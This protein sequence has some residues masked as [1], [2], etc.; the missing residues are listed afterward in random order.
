MAKIIFHLF[1]YFHKWLFPVFLYS[2]LL[3]VFVR[4]CIQ[5]PTKYLNLNFPRFSKS[6]YDVNKPSFLGQILACSSYIFVCISNT[7]YRSGFSTKKLLIGLVLR[8]IR[9]KFDPGLNESWH[10]FRKLPP[11]KIKILSCPLL[12]LIFS[13]NTVILHLLCSL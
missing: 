9:E 4:N 12:K 11:S 2:F 7:L 3:I 5:W 10:D 13:E 6:P 8:K 1:S